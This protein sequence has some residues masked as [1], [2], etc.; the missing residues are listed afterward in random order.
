[1]PRSRQIH[2]VRRPIGTPV[3]DDFALV[4]VDTP[5]AGPGEIQVQN[6]LM[7]VDPY[8]RPRLAGIRPWACR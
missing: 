2:L 3:R 5:D 8:M 6:L 7:S 4:T 1:M